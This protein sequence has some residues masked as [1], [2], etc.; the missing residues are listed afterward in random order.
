MKVKRCL[1][2]SLALALAAMLLLAGSALA[3]NRKGGGPAGPGQGNQL[4]TGGP[5]GTC[6]VS[7]PA[8]NQGNQNS[9]GYGAGNSQKRMGKGRGGGRANQPN[10]PAY[11]P[12][13]SQ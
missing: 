11:P 2:I 6:V 10:T 3:Q 12:A 9:P 4:C 7:P 5:G 1:S 13:A 8:N